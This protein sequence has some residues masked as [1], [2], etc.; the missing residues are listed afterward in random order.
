MMPIRSD[1]ENRAG[2]YPTT[3]GKG[4]GSVHDPLSFFIFQAGVRCLPLVN[5]VL[6]G[7]TGE[8]LRFSF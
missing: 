5:R 6:T 4:P 3:M 2:P 8:C 7:L 1:G